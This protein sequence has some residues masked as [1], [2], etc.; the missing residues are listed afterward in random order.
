MFYRTRIDLA[1]ADEGVAR[2]LFNHAIGQLDKAVTINTGHENEERGV[3]LIEEDYHDEDPNL[4]C[5]VLET[6][7]TPV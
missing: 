2:G 5:Y 3:V 6:H 4:P 7:S 1:F